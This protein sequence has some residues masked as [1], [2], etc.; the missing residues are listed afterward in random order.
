MLAFIRH[1][2]LLTIAPKVLSE[3]KIPTNGALHKHNC[4]YIGIYL[5]ARTFE[6][7]IWDHYSTLFS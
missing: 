6:N 5:A 3:H 1:G 7:P 4:L 2:R